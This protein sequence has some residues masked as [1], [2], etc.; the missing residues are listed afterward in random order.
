L[1]IA[2]I[3]D[4]SVRKFGEVPGSS[5]ITGSFERGSA[6]EVRGSSGGSSNFRG[7]WGS[8]SALSASH[9]C[10]ELVIGH[11]NG[12]PLRQNRS[13]FTFPEFVAQQVSSA[14]VGLLNELC[15]V[16]FNSLL[17]EK[18]KN[19]RRDA[20]TQRKGGASPDLRIPKSAGNASLQRSSLRAPCTN[21]ASYF[22][23]ASSNC[24][25]SS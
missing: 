15:L 7:D 21:P 17:W 19:S 12:K 18:E 25:M 24:M 3:R 20:K 9:C 2:W 4:R 11:W 23:S 10:L 8:K 1:K 16:N 14:D 5:E 13:P 22:F 6:Q